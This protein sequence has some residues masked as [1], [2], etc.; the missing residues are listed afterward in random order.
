M[1][2]PHNQD[3]NNQ[4]IARRLRSMI[5][6]HSAGVEMLRC[7]LRRDNPG[8]SQRQIAIKLGEHLR[9]SRHD[10]STF[11]ERPCSRFSAKS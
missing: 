8:A 3:Q 2:P 4:R 10:E 11:T 9:A 6:M 1:R 7:R 5:G